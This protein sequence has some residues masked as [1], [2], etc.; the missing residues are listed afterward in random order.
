MLQHQGVVLQN[1]T[2]YFE[3]MRQAEA[4]RSKRPKKHLSIRLPEDVVA[5]IDATAD[6]W[7]E[8][9]AANGATVRGIDRTFVVEV[10]LSEGLDREAKK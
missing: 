2:R 5:R 3:T 7:A 1:V 8:W 9:A 6:K 10:L 4:L